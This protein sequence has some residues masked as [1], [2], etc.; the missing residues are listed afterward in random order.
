[1]SA[2]VCTLTARPRL[3]PK[4]DDVLEE[5]MVFNV[6]PAIYIEGYGGIRH[7]DVVTVTADGMELLTPFQASVEELEL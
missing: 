1:M 7:C 6:E 2:L 3:H 5:G 4:S